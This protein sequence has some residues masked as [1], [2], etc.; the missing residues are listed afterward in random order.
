MAKA[1]FDEVFRTKQ[2][3]EAYKYFLTQEEIDEI[4]L[5]K[6]LWL[7][8]QMW[9]DRFE[10]KNKC[11]QLE[12]ETKEASAEA[13]DIIEDIEVVEPLIKTFKPKPKPKGK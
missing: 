8:A 4:L 12:H 11:M 2:F 7:D 3:R 1:K 13:D 6:N 9:C 5:G 10:H